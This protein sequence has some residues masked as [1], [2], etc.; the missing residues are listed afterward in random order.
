MLTLGRETIQEL[1]IGTGRSQAATMQGT[2]GG[3]GV[4]DDAPGASGGERWE[5]G[6]MVANGSPNIQRRLT[7]VSFMIKDFFALKNRDQNQ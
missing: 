5:L 7:K 1:S 4:D 6:E 3:E 2:P